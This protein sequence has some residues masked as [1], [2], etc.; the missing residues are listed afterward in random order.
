[1]RPA[2]GDGNAANEK[3][4][5]RNCQG[6]RRHHHRRRRRHHYRA[7][8]SARSDG[9]D[10]RKMASGDNVDVIEVVET[11]FSPLPVVDNRLG[12]PAEEDCE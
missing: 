7:W 5:S 3:A 8:V 4:S 11:N 9:G 10:A 12:Q 6:D 1:M 2:R